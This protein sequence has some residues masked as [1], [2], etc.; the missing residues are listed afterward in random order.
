M[1]T[2]TLKMYR[3]IYLATPIG[4]VVNSILDRFY[5]PKT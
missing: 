3:K 5:N 1:N 2:T 4:S